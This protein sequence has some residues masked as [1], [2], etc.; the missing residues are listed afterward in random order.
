MK[1]RF[2]LLNLLLFAGG[3]CIWAQSGT[4]KADG[5]PIPGATVRATLGERSLATITDE[6]G[7]FQL[8][9]L[10]PGAWTIEADM[11]GFAHLRREIQIGTAPARIDLT[12]QLQDRAQRAAAPSNP[13]QALA[14]ANGADANGTNPGGD[15]AFAPPPDLGGQFNPDS[16]NESFLVNGT[17]SRGLQ[18]TQA[19]FVPEFGPGGF[20]PGGP[21]GF[22]PGVPGGPGGP[23]DQNAQGGFGPGGPGGPG[24]ARGGPGGRFAGGGGGGGFPGGPGGFGGGGF[25]GRGGG[26]GGRGPGGRGGFGQG[27]G[28]QGRAGQVGGLVGNRSRRGANQIRGQAFFTFRNSALDAQP[29]SINGQAAPKP[30]YSQNRFGFNLGGPLAIPKLFDFSSKAQFTIN[31]QGT[32][33]RN[34]FDALT[35]VPVAAMRTGDFSSVSNIIYDPLTHEPFP[36]NVI[37]TSRLDPIALGLLGA[38]LIPLPNQPAGVQNYRLTNSVPSNNQ[39]FNARTGLT[40]T[41]TDRLAITF[42]VQN[43]NGNNLQTFGYRDETAGRGINTSIN[44]THNLTT[45]M[46]NNF[47]VSFNRNRNE[48]VPFFA[49]GTD[50]ATLLGIQ[51]TSSD[52]RNFGPP[53]LNFT[54]YG[55]LTDASPVRTATQT[56]GLQ[57]SVL[58]NHGKHN[59]SMGGDYRWYLTNT[60]TDSN[61]RGTFTFSGLATSQLN[62]QG[63]PVAGTGWDFADFLLGQAQSTSIRYGASSQYFR[64]NSYSAFGQDDW[65]V[66]SN[67]TLNLGL[68]YEFFSPVHE[69]YGRLANLDIA[70]GFTA[71]APVVSGGI[72]PYSGAFPAALINPDRNNFAPRVALSWKPTE[73]SQTTFRMGYGIY[74]NQGVYNQF[75]SRLAAQPPFA[76]SNT[77]NATAE[78]P[79]TLATGLTVTPVNKTITNTFAVDRNYRDAYAQAWNFSVQHNLPRGLV[80]EFGYNGTKGTRLD[81]QRLPNRAPPGSPLT[82]EDRRQIGN[83]VGFTYDSPDGNSIMHAASVRVTRR[84]RNYSSFNAQY[85][86]SKSIDNSSTFGG[87]G[88]TVAQDDHDLAAERGLS[89][90]DRRHTFNFNYQLQSPI[91]GRNAILQNH[92]AA[93]HALKDWT[94]TGTLLLQSGTPLTARVLGNVADTGGTGSIGSGRADATGL[95]VTGGSGYFNTLAFAVPPAGRFGDAGRNTIPGPGSWVMNL[96]LARSISLAERRSLELRVDA[97]NFLNHVN[98]S[99][100]GTVVNAV[101]YGLPTAAGA[102][103][104][105]TAT[106]RV[107]F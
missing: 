68:R 72:G 3:S 60:I 51:G 6:N 80:M 45:R 55:G 70:P 31:Y 34:P 79:L 28:P 38:N 83:A 39:N 58:W 1:M 10:T 94:L 99:N 48:T 101:D 74:Y 8:P 22:G 85:T 77:V 29:Y 40:L 46:F 78:L 106:A 88:N 57:E 15:N 91:G 14:D 73:R 13:A 98:V 16:S 63:Q 26:P 21:G 30:A 35:T 86:L 11:F 61:G 92:A 103:R 62:A 64:S 84:F 37:P 20:P 102:M 9:G 76:N 97:S 67:L 53:T 89:S 25:G 104:S 95:P 107:R 23:G 42:Q 17:L 49:Y 66:R 4:V 100:F 41:R 44:W 50:Y 2:F 43:R 27:R 65:R 69:K 52:P 12:L 59:V 93:Q 47:T 96:S 19:D 71:V 32:L 7:A 75:A 81:I 18:T 5:Q 87:A 105:L 36:N 90:F 56:F 54:N 33:G 24:G 82:A